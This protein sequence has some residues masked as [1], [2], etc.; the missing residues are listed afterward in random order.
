MQ[1]GLDQNTTFP[2]DSCDPS[3]QSMFDPEQAWIWNFD[4]GNEAF[5]SGMDVS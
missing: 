4:F 2:A 5:A 3:E 1:F